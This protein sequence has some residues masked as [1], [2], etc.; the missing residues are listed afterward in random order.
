MNALLTLVALALSGCVT[1]P[2]LKPAPERPAAKAR[3][4]A[5]VGATYELRAT[6][7]GLRCP[8]RIRWFWGRGEGYTDQK[9]EDCTAPAVQSHTY[10]TRAPQRVV[11][12][13][14]REGAIVA[15]ACKD[16][17]P[18]RGSECGE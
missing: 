18:R 6:F 14:W 8:D 3:A 4:W 1:A 12:E 11:I 13:F 2:V 17:P 5:R 7:E 15:T 10:Q 9:L 16:V